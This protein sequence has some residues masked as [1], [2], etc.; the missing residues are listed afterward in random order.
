MSRALRRGRPPDSGREQGAAIVTA[1]LVVVL[2]TT[3]VSTLFL[4]ESVA[5]RSIENRLSLSQTRWVER[6]AV[7]WAKVILR[8]DANAGNADHLGE[9]WA[10]PV[11]ETKLDETVTAGAKFGDNTRPATLAGEITD[12]QGRFNLNA[13]VFNGQL[14][15]PH[16]DAARKLFA[17]IDLP[18]SLVDAIRERLLRSQPRLVD[19]QLVSPTEIPLL[20]LPDLLGVP[21]FDVAMISRLEPFLTLIPM[22]QGAPAAT[23]VNLNTAA[24]E[25]ISAMVPDLDLAVVK[26]FVARRERTFFRELSEAALQMDG[27]PTLPP[28]LLSTGTS[29]FLLRGV[30]RFDRVEVASETLLV[31]SSGKVDIVWQQRL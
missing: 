18:E 19:G 17:L 5:V 7:D 13:I 15:K 3:V 12:M 14:S 1:L 24:A 9:P 21:G 16:E 28:L 10:V 11:A 20:R 26:R 8:A 22:I 27:Q 4:R 29:Y 31:R 6:A 30:V 23:Q 25:V 2:A